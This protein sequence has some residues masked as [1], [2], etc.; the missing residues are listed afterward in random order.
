M[1]KEQQTVQGRSLRPAI[2]SLTT[3]VQYLLDKKD[4]ESTNRTR[5]TMKKSPGE[6]ENDV[7]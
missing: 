1:S 4:K 3:Y 5:L 6:M 2:L 7:G